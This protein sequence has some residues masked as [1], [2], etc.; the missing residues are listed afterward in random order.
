MNTPIL[1]YLPGMSGDFLAWHIHKDE[2][3][4]PLS[5]INITSKNQ[6]LFPNMLE[7]INEDAKTFPSEKPWPVSAGNVEILRN[8][9]NNKNICFPTHWHNRLSYCLLPGFLTKGIR[10]YCQDRRILKLCY[11]MWW[12]KSHVMSYE[13]WDDRVVEIHQLMQLQDHRYSELSKLQFSFHNWKFL[14][15][16]HNLLLDGKLDLYTYIRSHFDKVYS[17]YNE[18]SRNLAY[19]NLTVDNVIYTG[20]ELGDLCDYLDIKINTQEIAAY[21]E[22]NLNLVESELGLRFASVEYD[23]DVVFFNLLTAFLRE[24]IQER[25]IYDYDYRKHGGKSHRIITTATRSSES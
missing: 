1:S 16:K 20:T 23:D 5:D 9:Y 14:A 18:P 17:K 12:I 3:F 25:P 4:Y 21:A 22:Q 10:L 6:F 11:F 19:L 24:R 8:L 13:P 2:K 7:S 15:L